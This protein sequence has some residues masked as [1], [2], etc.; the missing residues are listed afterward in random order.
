MLKK[1]THDIIISYFQLCT[2][3]MATAVSGHFL[4]LYRRN[5]AIWLLR[6]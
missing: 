3:T 2:M 1:Y 5:D 6:L 4:L